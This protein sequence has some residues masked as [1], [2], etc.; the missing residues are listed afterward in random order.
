MEPTHKKDSSG[1]ELAYYKRQLDKLTGDHLRNQYVISKLN[2]DIKEYTKGFQIL[3]DLHRSFS[4]L[5]PATVFHEEVLEAILS[6]MSADSV[7]LLKYDSAGQKLLPYLGK[8]NPQP[9][10][11]ALLSLSLP[12]WFYTERR[13]LHVSVGTS[14]TEPEQAIKEQ[15]K[16][17]YFILT[18]LFVNGACWGALYAG[19]KHQV[20]PMFLPFSPTDVYVFEAIAGMIASLTQQLDQHGALERERNRIAQEM[21]DDIGSGLT[22]IALLSELIQARK[23]VD[24]ATGAGISKIASTSRSLTDSIGEIIWALNPQYGTLADLL[25]YLRE[26]TVA[27][28]ESFDVSY[29]VLFPVEIPGIHLNN[30]QRRNL[31]LVIK[32]ALNNALKHSGADRIELAMTLEPQIICFHVIDNGSG[33]PLSNRRSTSNGL[34]N[35]TKR[36]SDLGGRCGI[37]SSEK[38]TKVSF[39]FP[40]S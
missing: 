36:M 8:G 26:Q 27:W 6:H 33:I 9:D 24:E 23:Q 16:Q 29:R 7:F 30:Q 40:I 15:L 32:E 22:H 39:V 11:M 35:L 34:R 17:P 3:A 2:T 5:K 10:D 20:R 28:L 4:F 19:R 31:Y 25:T 18:P 12:A 38:G 14:P 13:S 21:H 37:E 1:E